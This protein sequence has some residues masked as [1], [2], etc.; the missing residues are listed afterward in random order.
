[1][2]CD[3]RH[4]R[5][6]VKKKFFKSIL[7]NHR[8]SDFFPASLILLTESWMPLP[9]FAI[10]VFFYRFFNFFDVFRCTLF[11]SSSAMTLFL[12]RSCAKKWPWIRSHVWK[13]KMSFVVFIVIASSIERDTS[14]QKNQDWL[15]RP[16]FENSELT[17]P[18]FRNTPSKLSC[19]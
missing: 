3:N 19:N 8:R 17:R 16:T 7:L 5:K 2:R 12:T 14:G 15:V 18:T 1:M 6:I 13:Q 9:T 10:K 11:S 4:I